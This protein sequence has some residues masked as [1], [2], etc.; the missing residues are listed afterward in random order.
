MPRQRLLEDIRPMT[1][2]DGRRTG[3]EGGSAREH[4]L[5]ERP[6]GHPVQHLCPRG[7]HARALAGGENDDVGVHVL[8][9]ALNGS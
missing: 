1:D 3:T 4:M 6:P 5:D 2:D 8:I 7:L 9:I